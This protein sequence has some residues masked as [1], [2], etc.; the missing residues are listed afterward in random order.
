MRARQKALPLALTFTMVLLLGR[1]TPAQGP[2]ADIATTVVDRV[3]T[4]HGRQW[5]T[6]EVLD[7]VAE[8]KLMLFGLEGPKTTFDLTLLRKGMTRVLRVVHQPAGELR[9]GTDGV[10]SWESIPGFFTPAA[11]GRAMQFLEM[12]TTRSIQRLF[13]HQKEG[14][15]LQD[16]GVQDDWRVIEA[17]DQER[18]K[19]RYFIDPDKNLITKL[20]FI[21]REVKDP[22]SGAMVPL[23]DKYVFSDFRLTQG[24]VTPFKVERFNGGNKLEEM[25]FNI[26]RYNSGLKDADFRR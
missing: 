21:T 9:Q 8:G 7:S 2:T 23:T 25:Q 26:V 12:Q 4:A 14:L 22:F 1:T 17:E 15:K 6:G 5:A 20:E 19:T 13:N 18:K 24:I 10:N 11:Q 3:V 16:L